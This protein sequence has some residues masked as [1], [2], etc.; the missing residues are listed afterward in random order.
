[1]LHELRAVLDAVCDLS[2]V[3]RWDKVIAS[4]PNR[5][6][7]PSERDKLVNVV[8]KIARYREVAR[9]LYRT[10]KKFPIARNIH[11]VTVG[12][13]SVAFEETRLDDYAPQ[14]DSFFQ[15]FRAG[16][17]TFAALCRQLS[18][19]AQVAQSDFQDGTR[20]ILGTSR[21]HAEVQLLP[22]CDLELTGP[23]PR[24]ICSSKEACF[25]CNELIKAHG[26]VYTPY[27]HGRLY[28]PWRLPKLGNNQLSRQLSSMLEEITRNSL[29]RMHTTG[30]RIKY[31]HPNESAA[32]TLLLSSTTLAD[33]ASIAVEQPGSEA[34]IIASG[35]TGEAPMPAAGVAGSPDSRPV[36]P[37]AGRGNSI[38]SFRLSTDFEAKEEKSRIDLDNASNTSDKRLSG[39]SNPSG[40]RSPER[41]RLAGGK[42]PG[43]HT[44]SDVSAADVDSDRFLHQGTLRTESVQGTPLRV[45]TDAFDL[46]IHRSTT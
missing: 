36:K 1:M 15:R 31:H 33:P 21:V 16:K 4:I 8:T 37:I 46:L 24:V 9:Y 35:P 32:H 14:V 38:A 43:A 26:K 3:R 20:D 22:Y 44:A 45:S 28:S 12:L 2:D 17:Q 18:I 27:C 11:V 39:R 29:R 5:I 10:A 6:L 19:P 25:L 7:H 42:Q 13:P 30:S 23:R 40:R 41:V 34:R